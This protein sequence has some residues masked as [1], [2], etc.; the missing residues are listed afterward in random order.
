MLVVIIRCCMDSA[1]NI[2]SPA[3]RKTAPYLATFQITACSI[4]FRTD[5]LTLVQTGYMTTFF[6]L[7]E[8]KTTDWYV[9]LRTDSLFVGLFLRVTLRSRT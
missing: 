8:C 9:V 2:S 3:K 1:S 5:L 7:I 4:R 6:L